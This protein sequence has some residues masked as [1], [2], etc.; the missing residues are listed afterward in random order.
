MASGGQKPRWY[1]GDDLV[2]HQQFRSR[3][4]ELLM[5]TTAGFTQKVFNGAAIGAAECPA[6]CI[7]RL[8]HQASPPGSIDF[9][10]RSLR[11]IGVG[12]DVMRLR[13]NSIGSG[14]GY[15]RGSFDDWRKFVFF[16]L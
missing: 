8:T 12:D 3:L 13:S 6:P 2:L 1:S 16:E 15:R 11:T 9:S 5:E 10:Q 4:C 14:P 7:W